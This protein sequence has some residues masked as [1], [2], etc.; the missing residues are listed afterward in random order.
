MKTM[1]KITGLVIALVLLGGMAA[2]MKAISNNPICAPYKG[3]KRVLWNGA[4]LQKGQIGQVKILKN[5]PLYKLQGDKKIFSRTLKPK[6]VYR[7]YA[8][9][10]GK[11]GVGAG[12][13][14]DRDARIT[15][16]TPSKAKLL[17]VK[18]INNQ[19]PGTPVQAHFINV[20][21]GDSI[22]IQLTNSKTILVDGGRQDAGPDVVAYLK[23]IGVKTIDLM[24]GTH[25]DADHIGGLA[26][27]MNSLPVKQVL[28]SGRTSTTVTYK[29]YLTVIKNK[30]I[31]F[32]VAKVGQTITLDPSVKIQVLNSGAGARDDN[33]AS[34]SLKI[35]YGSE[36]I[37]LTGDAEA[38]QEKVMLGK[39]NVEAEIF[40]AAHHGSN[41]GN[42]LAFLQ[43]VHPKATV[44]SYA[45]N[46]S[47]GHPNADVVSRLRQIGSKVYSTAESGNIV[48][49]V[50]TSSFTV[51][52][53][54]WGG[55]G[56][57]A[58]PAPPVTETGK[59]KITGVDLAGEVALVKNEDTKDVTLT[60]WKLV[61][62]EGGQSF[63]FPAGYVL[64]AG[65]TVS[66][67]SGPTAKD[68]PPSQLAWTNASI[69][70]NQGDKAEL[71]NAQGVK[72][73]EF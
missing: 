39:F 41:T 45:I 60:G 17:A 49:T 40:K 43:E 1:K 10:P 21:Q 42:S 52:A 15:Y 32:V 69:W 59:V 6:E 53:S 35:S 65:S 3:V 54:P 13:Y 7:I 33:D 12:Y 9:L 46:N 44:L 31:P 73:S 23:K 5:T 64:K 2:P 56:A 72:V 29:N 11:L 34:V 36:D 66:I 55:A 57:P 24:V 68:Q 18:C 16:T 47:Y 37:L 19:V 67:T 26:T 70:N 30:R 50:T 22:L 8:F 51:T 14:L 20:G 63:T 4:V 61:S 58:P 27:V 25:P 48:F 71:Y 28:D 62:T 38:D